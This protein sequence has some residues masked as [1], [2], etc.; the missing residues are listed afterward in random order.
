MFYEDLTNPMQG[1]TG[2]T[3]RVCLESKI[4]LLNQETYFSWLE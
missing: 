2:H 1:G 3:Q 4:P